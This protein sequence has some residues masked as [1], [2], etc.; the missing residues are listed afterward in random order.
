MYETAMKAPSSIDEL[1]SRWPSIGAFADEIGCGYEA[2]RQM[3]MRGSIAPKH[4][5]NVVQ[6]SENRGVTGVTYE[7]LALSHATPSQ[8]VAE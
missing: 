8:Q 6:A 1:I 3:R 4:W 7:W 5:P 2:A